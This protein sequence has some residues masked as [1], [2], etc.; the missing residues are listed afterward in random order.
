VTAAFN[1]LV[2]VPDSSALGR[3]GQG[4]VGD[5]QWSSGGWANSARRAGLSPSR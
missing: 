2:L 3:T 4:P 5:Y 1:S